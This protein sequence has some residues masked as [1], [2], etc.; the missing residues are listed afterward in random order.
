MTAIS[1]EKMIGVIVCVLVLGFVSIS[2]SQEK[3]TDKTLISLDSEAKVYLDKG[4][5]NNAGTKIQDAYEKV[6]KDKS[7][8][9]P[10]ATKDLSGTLLKMGEAVHKKDG[11]DKARNWLEKAIE[12]DNKNDEAHMLLGWTYF[13]KKDFDKSLSFF[14]AANTVNPSAKS[15]QLMAVTYFQNKSY[16]KALEACDAGLKRN[17]AAEMASA[18]LNIRAMTNMMLGNQD[19]AKNDYLAA[20]NK[21]PG[22]KMAKNNYDKL[23]PEKVDK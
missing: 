4:D 10:A 23:Y 5:I 13:E 14:K 16:Q 15:Y 19:Q 1:K 7:S 9:S 21:D 6:T 8:L 12:I 17:P 22:N 2:N 3:V 20:I 18:I 11:A